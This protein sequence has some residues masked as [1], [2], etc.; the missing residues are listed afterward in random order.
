MLSIITL[1]QGLFSTKEVQGYTSWKLKKHL[2]GN[3]QKVVLKEIRRS[4]DAQ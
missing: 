3:Y 4:A 2:L 1:I